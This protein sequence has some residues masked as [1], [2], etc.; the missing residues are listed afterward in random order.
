MPCWLL[1]GRCCDVSPP[2]SSP[3][4][5]SP[6][7]C[8]CR[9]ST[10]ANAHTYTNTTR[11]PLP[12]P[13]MDV[14]RD[15]Q[16]RTNTPAHVCFLISSVSTQPHALGRGRA[17]NCETKNETKIPR[18]KSL[19]LLETVQSSNAGLP[20]A[21]PAGFVILQPFQGV[22]ICALTHPRKSSRRT[23]SFTVILGRA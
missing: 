1:R 18:S 17:F 14:L 19:L 21:P 15:A 13:I 2:P 7:L 9:Q 8:R 3:S 20:R 5:L 12:P 11:T 4:C 23:V 10:R 6:L 22:V 16:W